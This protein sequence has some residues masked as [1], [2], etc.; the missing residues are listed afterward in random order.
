MVSDALSPKFKRK[1]VSSTR[2]S[3][4]TEASS[5][6]SIVVLKFQQVDDSK[7]CKVVVATAR[8]RPE[9]YFCIP[10]E[11]SGDSYTGSFCFAVFLWIGLKVVYCKIKILTLLI[12]LTMV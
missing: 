7:Q 11:I 1:K 9:F 5:T 10:L 4:S 3:Q 8:L 12:P 6:V 2:C